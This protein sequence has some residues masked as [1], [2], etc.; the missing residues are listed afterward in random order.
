MA[1]RKDNKGRVLKTGEYFRK[2]DNRYSYIYTDFLGKKRTIYANSLVELRKKETELQRDIID[3][4]DTT[5]AKTT[6][7][8]MFLQ[9][10]DNRNDIKP[11]TRSNYKAMWKH[12][13]EDSLGNKKIADIKPMHIDAFYNDLSVSGHKRSTIK[14]ID[15]LLSMCFEVA[16]D[17]DFIRKNPCRGC[18]KKIKDDSTQKIALTEKQVYS[19]LKFC[20]GTIYNQYLPFLKIALATGMRIGEITGLTWNDVNM[21]EQ[22]INIDHALIYK[23]IDNTGCSF[24]IS[25][26]KTKAG[27][28]IIPMTESCFEAFHELRKMNLA[29]G[30]FCNVEIDGYSNFCF[31]TCNGQ[32]YATNGVNFFLKNIEKAYNET[33]PDNKIPHLSAHILRHTALSLLA[34]SGMTIKSLQA[35]AGHTDAS[36][37]MNVYCHSDADVVKQE[38]ETIGKAIN[39]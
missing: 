30:K 16:I 9:V 7:N 21:K 36:I 10:M 6:L 38:L 17:N 18:L 25:T 32:P 35:I 28:R 2:A 11:T 5:G 27:I 23:N 22:N 4:I 1:N 8:V 31:L 37:T 29:L 12:S 14:L 34:N 26:P 13:V 39:F 3:K 20:E 19:L 33:Y 15:S 24:H